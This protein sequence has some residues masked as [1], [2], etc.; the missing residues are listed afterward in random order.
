MN[1]EGGSNFVAALKDETG[2]TVKLLVNEIGSYGG[3]TF[4][5]VPSSESYVL[6]ITADGSWDATVLQTI[7]EE[8][9]SDPVTIEGTGDDVVF[10]EGAGGTKRCGIRHTGEHELVCYLQRVRL[11]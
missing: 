2:E 3:K 10:I 1:H 5:S 11:Y 6:D 4:F 8:M 7:P 9:E